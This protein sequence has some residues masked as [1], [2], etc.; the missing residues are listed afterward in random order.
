MGAQVGG[1]GRGAQDDGRGDGLAPLG[2]GA[3]EH[4]G[5]GHGRVLEQGGLD[6]GGHHV[7]AAGDDR[8]DLAAGD[9]QAAVRVEAAEV[10]RAQDAAARHGRAGDDDLTVGRDRDVEAGERR[11]EVAMSPG[12]ATVTAEQACVRP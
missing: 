10:A 6:L 5:L 11:P 9:D 8:V 3:A 1:I 7:L 2:V 12:S 4:A